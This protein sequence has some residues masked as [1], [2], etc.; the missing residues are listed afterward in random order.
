MYWE[1]GVAACS[2]ETRMSLNRGSRTQAPKRPSRTILN[3]SNVGYTPY[4]RK[5]WTVHQWNSPPKKQASGSLK[6]RFS[7]CS[8]SLTS[9]WASAQANLFCLQFRFWLGVL[10]KGT[11]PKLDSWEVRPNPSMKKPQIETPRESYRHATPGEMFTVSFSGLWHTLAFWHHPQYL[12]KDWSMSLYTRLQL[13]LPSVIFDTISF[14]WKDTAGT[15]YNH[16]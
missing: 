2:F 7:T 12:S 15:L 4:I 14:I 8:F 3:A 11:H 1:A 10:S 5:N 9:V 13:P 16:V 6:L